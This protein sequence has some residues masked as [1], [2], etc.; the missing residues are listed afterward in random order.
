MHQAMISGMASISEATHPYQATWWK[1]ALLIRPMWYHFETIDGKEQ[2]LWA[3]GNPLTF[4]IGFACVLFFTVMFFYKTYKKDRRTS[5]TVLLMFYWSSVLF[6]VLIPRKIKLMYY[7]LPAS[8]FL[9]PII[10]LALEKIQ[11]KQIKVIIGITLGILSSALF[12]YFMPILTAK[13]V[14]PGTFTKYLLFQSW[15]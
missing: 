10:V 5:E 13:P 9:G 1:W 2:S 11:K 4:W 14:Q 12:Y 7:Y 3:G 6:W 15:L 8:L